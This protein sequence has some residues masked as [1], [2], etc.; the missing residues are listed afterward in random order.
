MTFRIDMLELA[1]T[2]LAVVW[3]QRSTAMG[4]RLFYGHN[5]PL[6]EVGSDLCHLNKNGF[7]GDDIWD[8]EDHSIMT[9]DSRTT[10]GE[11][12]NS[13]R[14]SLAWKEKRAHGQDF[15]PR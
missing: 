12:V 5:L 13:T 2:A 15:A 14:K 10:K 11:C 8:K 4:R 6:G 9:N 1:A 7:T 3:A